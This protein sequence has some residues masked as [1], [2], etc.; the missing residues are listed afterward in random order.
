MDLINVFNNIMNHSLFLKI[1][2]DNVLIDALLSTFILSSIGYLVKRLAFYIEGQDYSSWSVSRDSIRSLFYKKY[3]LQIEG[4][5][6]SASSP[7]NTNSSIS[8]IPLISWSCFIHP[9]MNFY[10]FFMGLIYWRSYRSPFDT[11]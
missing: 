9:N 4:Q 10:S 5:K 7:Y 6:I 2:T 8:L 3:I 1:K 11:T